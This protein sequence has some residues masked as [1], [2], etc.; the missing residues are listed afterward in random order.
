MQRWQMLLEK[1]LHVLLSKTATHQPK[2]F[3]GGII[4][5]II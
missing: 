1:K 5:S 2:C 4:Q 3:Y